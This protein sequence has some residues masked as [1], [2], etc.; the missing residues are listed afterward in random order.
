MIEC[1]V[2][3]TSLRTQGTL[4]FIIEASV[5]NGAA[6]HPSVGT[7]VC[8]AQ[9]FDS[10]RAQQFISGFQHGV[11]Y[12]RITIQHG[13]HIASALVEIQT[14]KS[15]EKLPIST[16]CK[17]CPEGHRTAIAARVLCTCALGLVFAHVCKCVDSAIQ[18]GLDMVQGKK[19]CNRLTVIGVLTRHAAR[20]LSC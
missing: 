15:Q 6:L 1:T 20:L 4:Y 8:E 9:G 13:I 5:A 7:S 10:D 17:Y 19:P 18:Y 16:V 12:C 11:A 14:E 2:V 3:E